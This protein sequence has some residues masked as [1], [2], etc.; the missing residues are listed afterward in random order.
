MG[1]NGVHAT[2]AARP[3][4][5]HEAL[6]TQAMEAAKKLAGLSAVPGTVTTACMGCVPHV[7]L[8]TGPLVMRTSNRSTLPD[9]RPHRRECLSSVFLSPRISVVE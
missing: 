4:V 1:A 5:V 6:H 7:W 3:A 8:C 2:G 9:C